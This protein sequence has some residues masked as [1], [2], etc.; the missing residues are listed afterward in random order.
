M[1]RAFGTVNDLPFDRSTVLTKSGNQYLNVSLHVNNQFDGH[2]HH[3]SVSRLDT[4]TVNQ[5]RIWQDQM[6]E[7]VLV[8]L[9]RGE[10]NV[11]G[12]PVAFQQK[13]VVEN[14]NLQ[15]DTLFEAQM[16]QVQLNIGMRRLLE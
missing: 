2:L 7:S 15:G 11:V 10:Q 13:L 1:H 12:T 14:L 3:L 9:R 8:T 5:Q 4:E 16:K 6:D